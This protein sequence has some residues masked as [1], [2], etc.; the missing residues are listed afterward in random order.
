M[1]ILIIT[2][3]TDYMNQVKPNCY[4]NIVQYCAYQTRK[5]KYTMKKMIQFQNFFKY[6]IKYTVSELGRD[7]SYSKGCKLKEEGKV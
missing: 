6:E 3:N 2:P 4:T 7:M 5:T 1:D